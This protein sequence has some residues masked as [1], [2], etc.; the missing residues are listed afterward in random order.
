MGCL[1]VLGTRANRGV[2]QQQR[3]IGRGDVRARELGP[4]HGGVAASLSTTHRGC[5]F[6]RNEKVRSDGQHQS[7]NSIEK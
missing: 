7:K 1:F 2:Q 5:L 6:S 3:R 4:R